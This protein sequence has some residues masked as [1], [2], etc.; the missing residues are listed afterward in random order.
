MKRIINKAI[1][2]F[3]AALLSSSCHFLEV[4]KIG[5]SDI[6]SFFE[7]EE[8]VEAAVTGCMDLLDGLV[9]D[10]MILY[11]E[12]CG[13]LVVMNASES[14][15]W[16]YLYNFDLSEAYNT[17]P[18]GFVWNNAYELVLNTCEIIDYAPQVKNNYPNAASRIDRQVAHAHYL[19]A[20][21]TFY[22]A[23]CYS[24]HYT[25]SADASHLGVI[26]MSSFP[27]LNAEIIRSDAASTYKFI[28]SDLK[29]AYK[30]YEDNRSPD[31]HY[32]SRAAVQ[33]LLARIYLYM[34][35]Y[36]DAVGCAT[37]VIDNYDFTL[38]PRDGYF[39]MFTTVSS[40][41][42]ESIF[43]LNGYGQNSTVGKAFDYQTYML[44]PSQ[45]LKSV[46]KEDAI[47][48]AADVRESLITFDGMP[49]SMGC[50]MKYTIL[51]QVSDKEKAVDLFVSRLSEM[52][53]IRAE[54]LAHLGRDLDMA[55]DDVARIR[56]RA[57]GLNIDSCRP[58]LNPES[59]LEAVSRERVKE[60]Y[61]EGHRLFDITRRRENLERD[62]ATTSTVRTMTYPNDDFIFPIPGIEMEANKAMQPNPNNETQR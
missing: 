40:R 6:E 61:H 33:A 49:K 14:G 41:G 47:N 52:Y 46:F 2:L 11:P 57:T 24:Q 22:L 45:K 19:R 1:V 8:S 10:Y 51:E 34:E 35:D 27:D 28:V 58:A 3:A 59:I 7:S 9:D 26:L 17:T 50:S 54:A 62:E 38:T 30:L 31:P 21:A 12:I 60:F 4:D 16:S 53:L 55:A 25:Y 5:K 36:E 43:R 42:K 56:S 15:M 39:D 44:L 29:E 23:L 48:G 37:D 13:D 32:P 20:I 18:I